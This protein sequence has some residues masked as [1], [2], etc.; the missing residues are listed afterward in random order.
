MFVIKRTKQDVEYSASTHH[1]YYLK[2]CFSPSILDYFVSG[3]VFIATF[4][5]SYQ[6]RRW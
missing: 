6:V 2:F 5:A 4:I 1:S 3:I